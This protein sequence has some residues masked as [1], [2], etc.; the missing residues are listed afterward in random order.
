MIEEYCNNY[1]LKNNN[2]KYKF[3]L[4]DDINP[5][6][7]T[8]SCFDDLRVDKDHISRKP[9]D[10]YYLN[11]NTV[12]TEAEWYNAVGSVIGIFDPKIN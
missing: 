2:G 9:S 3:Q 1:A 8:K 12:I 7:D 5:I 6:V 10:T 11:E 4:Y